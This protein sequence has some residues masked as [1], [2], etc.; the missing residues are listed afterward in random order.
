MVLKMTYRS[1]LKSERRKR[2]IQIRDDYLD[3]I[4]ENLT[5]RYIDGT[6]NAIKIPYPKEEL[7]K[8]FL[9]SIANAKE[10]S[11]ID[12][13][14]SALNT[15]AFHTESGDRNFYFAADLKHFSIWTKKAVAVNEHMWPPY[16]RWWGKMKPLGAGR[17]IPADWID[18]PD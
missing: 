9:F 5:E 18:F 4:D 12:V 13:F 6:E 7:V 3:R 8:A 17:K 14:I 10:R 15:S 1:Q 2:L 16:K 11:D